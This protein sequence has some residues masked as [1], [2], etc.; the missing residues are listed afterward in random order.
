MIGKYTLAELMHSAN[1]VGTPLVMIPL[2]TYVLLALRA[3]S[4]CECAFVQRR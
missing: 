4:S 2:Y 1:N 3:K